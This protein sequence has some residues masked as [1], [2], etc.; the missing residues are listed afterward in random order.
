MLTGPFK[1]LKIRLEL[2]GALEALQTKIYKWS[3]FLR[4]LRITNFLA[5]WILVKTT[6]LCILALKTYQQYTRWHFDMQL[7]INFLEQQGG[8][9]C[10]NGISWAV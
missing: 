8:E 7:N 2:F 1:F 6:F 9:K 3:D 10:R 4:A 5:V